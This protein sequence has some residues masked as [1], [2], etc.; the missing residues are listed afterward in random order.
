MKKILVCLSLFLLLAVGCTNTM[1]TP[2]KK[3]EELLGKYQKMDSTILA[4]LDSVI[5]EDV[6]MSDEQKKEYRSLMEKQYQNL[7]YKVKNEEIKGNNA[8][9][10]VEIEVFDYATS[11]AEARKY[12]SEHKDEFK[13]EEKDDDTVGEKV[14]EAIDKSS[15][16]IDY[17]IKQLKNV[18]DKKKYDITFNLSKDE[19]GIWKLDDISD[20]D[21]QKIHGLYED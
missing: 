4:Q 13:D 14:E 11:I 21:R 5:S 1:N 18:T 17:K 9:V 2:T 19:D 10:D 6:N 20:I 16:Y 15:K 12:Y 3:V 8:T 7:S